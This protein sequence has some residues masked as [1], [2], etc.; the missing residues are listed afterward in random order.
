MSRLLSAM[1]FHHIG[2]A[3]RN[4]DMDEKIFSIFGYERE[5]TE[6]WDPIQGVR[7]RFFVGGGPRIELL[8]D[9]HE[10]G[11]LAPWLRKGTKF[12]HMA[13]EVDDLAGT[14]QTLLAMGAKQ[15]VAP[16]PAVAFGGRSIC[17]F[18]L[19]NLAL[20]ELISRT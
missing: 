3:C 12:Y 19:P 14:T 17:F 2:V 10:E 1:S 5:G 13:Y 7:G 15:T 4:L 20:V 9:E 8:Q 18:M 16:V 11:M 6:F